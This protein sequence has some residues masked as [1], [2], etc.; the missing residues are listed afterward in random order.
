M[1]S[2]RDGVPGD[3][4]SAALVDQAQLMP[5]EWLAVLAAAGWVFR[6]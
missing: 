4:P 3:L 2:R 1:F 6:R 5:G